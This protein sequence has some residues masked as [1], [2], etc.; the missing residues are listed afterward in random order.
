VPLIERLGRLKAIGDLGSSVISQVIAIR[1]LPH[2]EPVRRLRRQELTLR[3]DLLL[4]TLQQQAP[5]WGWKRPEGGLFVWAHVPATDTRDLA[6]AAL[7]AGLIITPGTTLSVDGEHTN[8]LRL[9][10]L[11]PPARLQAG[12]ER[13]LE[14]WKRSGNVNA[15][16]PPS[17]FERVQ[18]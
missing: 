12:I 8:Y 6:Q 1:L 5:S 11:L 18:G 10:F 13:L 9:P 14:V 16:S 17:T 4:E 2:L 3:R 7:R 15:G